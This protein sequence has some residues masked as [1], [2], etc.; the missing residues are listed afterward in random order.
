M[1]SIATGNLPRTLRRGADIARGAR[2]RVAYP[3]HRDQRR[4]ELAL[5]AGG[6]ELL[7]ERQDHRSER[8]VVDGH[9]AERL[10][11][12]QL[13]LPRRQ[14]L[15]AR[16]GRATLAVIRVGGLALR[17]AGLPVLLPVTLLRGQPPRRQLEQRPAEELPQGL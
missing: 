8:S 13:R 11:Q 12:R 3:R 17:V 6:Q 15:E 10:D 1:N 2:K 4:R 14:R 5:A 7:E 9:V 16:A